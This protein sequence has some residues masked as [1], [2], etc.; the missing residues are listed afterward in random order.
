[1]FRVPFI[2]GLH[3]N[4][5]RMDPVSRRAQSSQGLAYEEWLKELGMF[6]VQRSQEE[7]GSVSDI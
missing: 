4:G 1:M 6:R 2:M 3:R 5:P 7:L